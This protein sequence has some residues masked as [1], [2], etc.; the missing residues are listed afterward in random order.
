MF[1]LRKFV[2]ERV[3]L[4]LGDDVAVVE[5]HHP[6]IARQDCPRKNE[7]RSTMASVTTEELRSDIKARARS[8]ITHLKKPD[9]Q[10]CSKLRSKN[11]DPC[12]N[13]LVDSLPDFCVYSS[14][15]NKNMQRTYS[16]SFLCALDVRPTQLLHTGDKF[17]RDYKCQLQPSFLGSGSS[18]SCASETCCPT[19]LLH[20]N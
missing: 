6:V 16:A 10:R 14:S 1:L 15:A 7:H 20:Q 12:Q 9:A 8:E 2:K 17:K 19:F 11:N 4:L 5:N 18:H 3:V 13:A